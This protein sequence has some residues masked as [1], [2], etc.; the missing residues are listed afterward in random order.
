MDIPSPRAIVR[1]PV[2]G[3]WYSIYTPFGLTG[4]IGLVPRCPTP[5]PVVR[6]VFHSLTR[7]QLAS[8]VLTAPAD[9]QLIGLGWVGLIPVDISRT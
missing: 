9:L 4:R 3:P 1:H 7:R 6:A 8:K 2:G 5:A